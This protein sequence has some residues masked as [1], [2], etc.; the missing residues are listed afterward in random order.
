MDSPAVSMRR[1][2]AHRSARKPGWLTSVNRN[3]QEYTQVPLIS[4]IYN[5]GMTFYFLLFQNEYFEP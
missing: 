4:Q 1:V 3:G 5:H 2:K